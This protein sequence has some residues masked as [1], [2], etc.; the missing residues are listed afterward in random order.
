MQDF[1]S[2]INQKILCI[3]FQTMY[4]EYN[5]TEKQ[6]TF[7]LQAHLKFRLGYFRNIYYFLNIICIYFIKKYNLLIFVL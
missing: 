6:T 4:I 5:Y 2:E 1:R 7:L 3:N